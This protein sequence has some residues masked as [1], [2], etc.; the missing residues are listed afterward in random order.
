MPCQN[1]DKAIINLSITLF[2]IIC[3]SVIHSY[4][5]AIEMTSSP[6]FKRHENLKGLFFVAATP[7]RG[8]FS[9]P[10]GYLNSCPA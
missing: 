2:R 4:Q 9:L 10:A 3:N 5:A 1:H 7:Q 6:F 8:V